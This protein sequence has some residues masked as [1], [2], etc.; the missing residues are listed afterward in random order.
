M[1]IASNE[2]FFMAH[3]SVIHSS[4]NTVYS[5]ACKSNLMCTANER[6]R[7]ITSNVVSHWQGSTQNETRSLWWPLSAWK[8]SHHRFSA[9]GA[10]FNLGQILAYLVHFITRPQLYL[11]FFH[12]GWP[13]FCANTIFGNWWLNCILCVE[14]TLFLLAGIILQHVA[15]FQNDDIAACLLWVL[16]PPLFKCYLIP[17]NWNGIESYTHS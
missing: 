10:V 4:Q 5:F 2:A 3:T 9:N 1:D 11:G 7:Y 8:K 6:W 17:R 15:L 12:F 16:T 14:I 13:S